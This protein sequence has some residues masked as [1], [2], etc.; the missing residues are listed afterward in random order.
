[1]K[2][3]SFVRMEDGTPEDYRAVMEYESA[4]HAALP[5]RL[6]AE[7]RRA[8]DIQGP[9]KVTR[10]E[11]SLQTATRALRDGASEEMVVAALLHD[12]GDGLAPANHSDLAAAVLRPYVSEETWWVVKHHGLFQGYYYFHH[13]GFDR[14]AR[15]QYRDHPHYEATARFCHDWDQPAFDPGYE[16]EPIETFE[17]MVHRVFAANPFPS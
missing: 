16:S 15:D 7:L 2:T 4:N 8:G 12:I 14:N 10:Y 11:H 17:P 9:W 1:M 3:V 13:L 6:L 5:A